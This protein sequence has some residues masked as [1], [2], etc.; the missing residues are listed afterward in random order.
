MKRINWLLPLFLLKVATCQAQ[1]ALEKMRYELAESILNNLPTPFTYA[2]RGP[3]GRY[4]R[5]PPMPMDTPTVRLLLLD[6]PYSTDADYRMVLA[7]EGTPERAELLKY[8]SPTD[9]A[10]MRQ[11]LP[12]SQQFRFEQAKV[13]EPWVTIVPL[14]SVLA[15]NKRLG[16]QAQSLGRDTLFRRYG[17]DRIFAIWG[18][19]FSKNHKRA[20]VNTADEGWRTCVYTKTKTGWR[21]TAI[22]YNI[23]Y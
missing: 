11:Q 12:V 13:R 3:D 22:L 10:Y 9:V 7:G 19:F 18:A 5:L 4:H 16:W 17:A 6:H 14:D 20:L 23:V 8:L 1:Q 21:R 2:K 15:I